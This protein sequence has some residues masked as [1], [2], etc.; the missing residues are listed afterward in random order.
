MQSAKSQSRS[1]KNDRL[2]PNR[3]LKSDQL[4]SEIGRNIYEENVKEFNN[5]GIQYIMLSLLQIQCLLA[6]R[7]ID[8]IYGFVPNS[9]NVVQHLLVLIFRA[10]DVGKA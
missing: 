2:Y 7:L 9:A 8:R 6:Q 4:C 5:L 3:E 10:L 1:K